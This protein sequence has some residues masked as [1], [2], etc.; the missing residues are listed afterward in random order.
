MMHANFCVPCARRPCAAGMNASMRQ[1]RTSG[2]GRQHVA[3]RCYYPCPPSAH[4][5]RSNFCPPCS[6]PCPP[7]CVICIDTYRRATSDYSV[8]CGV[9]PGIRI[10]LRFG[11]AP[12]CCTVGPAHRTLAAKRSTPLSRPRHP[13]LV[14]LSV[15]YSC[16]LRSG[17]LVAS[18][19]GSG[20]RTLQPRHSVCC[21]AGWHARQLLMLLFRHPPKRRCVE[22]WP[23]LTQS[24]CT[25]AQ[26]LELMHISHGYRHAISSVR[27]RGSSSER[28]GR[29]RSFTVVD[30]DRSFWAHRDCFSCQPQASDYSSLSPSATPS[31]LLPFLSRY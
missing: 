8:A 16:F 17:S 25:E 10:W 30:L 20:H 21:V 31:L 22:P 6:T 11:N 18:S 14:M 19:K 26:S 13:C 5:S 3:D 1:T 29:Q 27:V 12:T 9:L 23:A 15:R 4:V 7:T 24:P 2:I 28:Q